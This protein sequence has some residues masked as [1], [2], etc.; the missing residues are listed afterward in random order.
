MGF[1]GK[2]FKSIFSP[3]I[4]STY[5]YSPSTTQ[6]CLTGRDLVAST[7]RAAPEAPS[8]GGTDKKRRRGIESLLVPSE[9][10]CKGGN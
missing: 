5:I 10:L 8:M 6:Q 4:L 2:V 1:V 9:Y 7:G 3:S